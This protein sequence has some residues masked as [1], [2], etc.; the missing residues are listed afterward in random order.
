MIEKINKVEDLLGAADLENYNKLGHPDNVAILYEAVKNKIKEDDE[1]EI[2]V[3][4]I[5]HR[6]LNRVR[7]GGDPIWSFQD[8]YVSNRCR[9]ASI[10][11]SGTIELLSTSLS[12]N[13][14]KVSTIRAMSV[15][16]GISTH[17]AMACMFVPKEE[18]LADKTLGEL[19]VNHKNG[20]K[21]DNEIGNLEWVTQSR[22]QQHAVEIGL[23]K[24][25]KDNKLTKPVKGVIL[26]GPYA[27][28]E[29]VLFGLADYKVYGFVQPNV[30]ACCNGRLKSHRNCLFTLA[31]EKEIL[32]LPRGLST[33]MHS[34]LQF[35]TYKNL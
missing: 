8:V 6:L 14:Y 11:S 34:S 21:V 10:N 29:F 33:E 35:L 32:E 24:S 4:L 23:I 19:E 1:Y 12:I 28:H 22:N 15:M 2:W 31:T 30:N 5:Y 13:G 25:G 18:H 9:L 27:G 3:P 16:C 20:I 7:K 26:K 17:R